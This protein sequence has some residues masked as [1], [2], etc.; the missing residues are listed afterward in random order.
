VLALAGFVLVLAVSPFPW[1]RFGVASGL[2][3]AWRVHWSLL[4]LAS[5]VA[6]V[7]VVVLLRRGTLGGRLAGLLIL[8]LAAGVAVGAVLHATRPPP[9]SNAAV[10]IPWRAAVLGAI[11]AAA[12]AVWNAVAAPRAP[13]RR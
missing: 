5:A 11:L 10:T 3:D 13:S 8:A 6:G 12:G 2:G 9:T 7:V 4:A 1:S